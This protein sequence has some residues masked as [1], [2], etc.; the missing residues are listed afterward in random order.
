MSEIHSDTLRYANN[1]VMQFYNGIEPRIAI[2]IQFDNFS[3]VK[4]SY[5]RNKQ[6][7]SLISN[8]AVPNP[9][10]FWKLT[11]K[12]IKPI[13]CSHFAIGFY[14]NFDKNKF[15]TSVEFYYK[16]LKNLV[17]Y[18]N[19]AVLSL[20]PAIETALFNADGKN[21]GVEFFV[22]RNYGKVDGWLSYTYSRSTKKTDSPFL[23]EI[24]SIASIIN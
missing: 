4:L 16:A 3:S 9:N 17:E 6:Y 21:Y 22:K 18:K 15:E 20:N 1:A 19:G 24:S 13:D 5:N 10:D 14:R 8:T 11:D 12:Y 23:E 2:K 7:L